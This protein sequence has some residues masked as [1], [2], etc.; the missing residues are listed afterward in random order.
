MSGCNRKIWYLVKNMIGK[1]EKLILIG[2]IRNECRELIFEDLKK[3]SISF[4]MI[5]FYLLVR[6]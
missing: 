3:V 4:L 1:V 6:S 5:F 2:L